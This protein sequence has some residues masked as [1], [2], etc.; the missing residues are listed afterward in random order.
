MSQLFGRTLRQA[1]ADTETANHALLLRAAY[2]RQTGTGIYSA[3]TLGLRMQ[4]NIEAIIREEIDRIGGQEI[5]MPVV[6][7][8]ELWK[9]TGRYYEIGDEL[10]RFRDRADRELVLAMTHEET[11]AALCKSEINSYRQLP[12]NIY[13]IQTKWRDDP[14][15]RAGLIRV[16]EF[17]MKDSYSLDA[18]WD[19]LDL[20]YQNHFEAYHRIFARCGL[21]VTAVYSDP[22]MMGGKEAHEFM[23]LTPIGED[24]ILICESCGYTANRQVAR[25][26]KLLPEGHEDGASAA[27][28]GEDSGGSG[29]APQRVHTPDVTTIAELKQF[30]GVPASRLAKAYFAIATLR[31]DD[32]DVTRFVLGIIRGDLEVNETKLGQAV[33][34]KE[35]RPATDEEIRAIGAEPGYGGPLGLP[36]SGANAPLI[37]ADDSVPEAGAMVSGANEA[38]YHLR[39]VRYGRDY[40]ADAVA[41][42]A[43]AHDGA[44]CSACGKPLRAHRAV[45]V[46]N[47]FKL[48]TGYSESVGAVF[49]DAEGNEKPIVMGSYGIG[50]GRLL[51]SIAEE[52]HDE[53]G[54]AL[55]ITVAPYQIHVVSLNGGEEAAESLYDELTDGGYTVLLDDRDERPGVKFNDADLMGSPIRVTVGGKGLS[56]GIMEMRDR[57][58]GETEEISADDA[59]SAIAARVAELQQALEP[60]EQLS[61]RG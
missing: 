54:M 16:R 36:R 51:A 55:P 3:L 35:L 5:E 27:E 43:G 20:Q 26:Q 59:V 61:R 52:H 9:Q 29:G 42:I 8:A 34:A 41:D 2:I 47:I 23:Y 45:E 31:E 33:G 24:T 48:G 13:Q 60:A 4:R 44:A 7:P 50:I 10:T 19:G 25:F 39:N 32:E 40:T 1:P 37:V 38:G 22:G 53:Q 28:G 17:G 18:D 30:L 56:R 11:V 14:R 12:R 21:P 57:K 49:L 58:S 46:G 15:P 6:H